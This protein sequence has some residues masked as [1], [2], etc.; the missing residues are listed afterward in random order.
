MAVDIGAKQLKTGLDNMFFGL[1]FTHEHRIEAGFSLNK[2]D[3]LLKEIEKDTSDYNKI[4]K[5]YE[6]IAEYARCKI[7]TDMKNVDYNQKNN[8]ITCQIRASS[9]LPLK[10]YLFYER[11]SKI[12]YRFLEIPAFSG[13]SVLKY[14]V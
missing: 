13:E 14:N 11:D 6:Y 5:S 4:Y 1:M 10:L 12:E 7:E 2:W 8:E 3:Q 9:T